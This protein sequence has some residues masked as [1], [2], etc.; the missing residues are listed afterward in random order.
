M[1]GWVAPSLIR[2]F[3]RPSISVYIP[4]TPYP[5][6]FPS[7]HPPPSLPPSLPPLTPFTSHQAAAYGINAGTDNDLGGDAVYH[8]HLGDAIKAGMV[9]LDTLKVAV[10]RNLRLRFQLGD[11]DPDYLVPYKVGATAVGGWVGLCPTPLL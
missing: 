5:S 2:H 6:H 11:F 7:R 9:T 8:D 1:G 3:L 10:S 4:F